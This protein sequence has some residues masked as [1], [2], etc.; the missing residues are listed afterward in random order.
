MRRNNPIYEMQFSFFRTGIKHLHSY[1]FK[2]LIIKKLFIQK[3]IIQKLII[4]KPI[5]QKFIIQ[6]FILEELIKP[7]I[8]PH[9]LSSQRFQWLHTKN[10]AGITIYAKHEDHTLSNQ[11]P[12]TASSKAPSSASK[13][14]RQAT[15][16]PSTRSSWCTRSPS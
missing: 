8:S 14:A 9:W 6:K 12:P 13:A 16:S 7:R 11:S 4:Q 1:N 3:L 5:I 10:S 2:K 15:A